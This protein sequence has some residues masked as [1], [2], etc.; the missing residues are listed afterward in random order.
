[1]RNHGKTLEGAADVVEV[2]MTHFRAA[3]SRY[4]DAAKG[5]DL[6]AKDEENESSESAWDVGCLV[7]PFML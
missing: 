5:T 1:M 2:M 4:V 3:C 6:N 7:R